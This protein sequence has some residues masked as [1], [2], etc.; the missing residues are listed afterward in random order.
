MYY[1]SRTAGFCIGSNISK[2]KEK[3]ENTP[4]TLAFILILPILAFVI[5]GTFTM[6]PHVK[7][8]IE[9]SN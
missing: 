8:V 1:L 4:C 7:T 2:Y 3:R 9:T 5:L 6:A